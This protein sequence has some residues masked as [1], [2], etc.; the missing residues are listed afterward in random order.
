[1]KIHHIGYAV[2]DIEKS[3]KSFQ[4]IGY[5]DEGNIVI[6]RARSIKILFMENDGQRVELIEPYCENGQGG[7]ASPVDRYLL[8]QKDMAVPYHL[9]Y[10]VSDIDEKIGELRKQKFLLVEP[11]KEAPAINDAKV[12]FL[13]KRTVGLIELAEV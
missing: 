1:M 7:R 12:A 2:K 13:Y 8:K 6:D 3:K 5:R 4:Q 9:C 10:E 11:P